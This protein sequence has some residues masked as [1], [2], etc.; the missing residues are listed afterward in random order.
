MLSKITATLTLILWLGLFGFEFLESPS[1]DYSNV[2]RSVKAA[3]AS[4]G[5]AIK[6]SDQR[7]QTASD[8]VLGQPKGLHPPVIETISL[9]HPAAKADFQKKAL[10]IHKLYRVF[11]I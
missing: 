2:H 7:Q 4:L 3:L 6:I 11:L 9:C 10:K 1:A 5:F 8:E